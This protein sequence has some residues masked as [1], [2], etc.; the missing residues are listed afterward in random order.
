M[1]QS[2]PF[3][4]FVENMIPPGT[5]V[6]GRAKVRELFLAARV[7][8]LNFAERLRREQAVADA[9]NALA[10]ES[11]RREP[12]DPDARRVVCPGPCGGKGW[13]GPSEDESEPCPVC[14]GYRTILAQAASCRCQGSGWVADGKGAAVV[15]PDCQAGADTVN[16]RLIRSGV[17]AEYLSWTLAAW[18]Q[19]AGDQDGVALARQA[20]AAILDD[21]DAWVERSGRPGLFLSSRQVG[22]G[23]TGLAV[24]LAAELARQGRTVAFVV[25]D[26]FL[27]ELKATFSNDDPRQPND[28][29]ARYLAADVLVIDDL[30]TGGDTA[31]R[32]EQ[33]YHLFDTRLSAFG[34]QGLTIVTSNLDLAQIAERYDPRVASRLDRLCLTVEVDGRD[35]RAR[36]SWN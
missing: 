20:V 15:C 33:A 12:V 16:R 13:V 31:W 1:T 23:K 11:R 24:V 36:P 22:T 28:V 14:R 32:T 7:P 27:D 3:A 2:N 5:P 21:P 6:E 34:R 8:G 25:F 29:F 18:D 10:P 9:L 4:V 19:I 17:P 35:L 30:G 26:R